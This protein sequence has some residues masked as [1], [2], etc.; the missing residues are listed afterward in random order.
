[1]VR[2][3]SAGLALGLAGFAATA[4]AEPAP[5][6]RPPFPKLAQEE[7]AAPPRPVPA[8]PA[9][10]APAQPVPTP[11]A[12]A[13]PAQ[14][15]AV[16]EPVKLSADPTPTLGPGTFVA[17][18]NA[19]ERYRAIAEAG[20]WA[21]V[22]N[23]ITR[24]KPGDRGPHV[25]ALRARLIASGDLSADL[26][27]GDA[28]DE[29]VQAAIRRFQDRHG[30][31]ALGLVGPRTLVELN[32][33]V[34]VRIR[35]LQASANRLMGSRFPFG[36]RYVAVNIPAATVEAVQGGVVAKRHVAVV[37]KTDRPSPTI[38]ARI[39]NVNFNPTWTVPV[40]LIRKDIIP[41]M[42]KDPGYLAR[43]KIR[44]FDGQGAEIDPATIDWSTDKAATYTLR[45]DPG[46]DNSLGEIRIDMPN[47]LAVY[48]HDTPSKKLF[49][50]NARNLSSGCVRVS[51]IRELAQW[52]LEGQ[53]GP[54][55]PGSSWGQAEIAAAIASGQRIDVKLTR[56][57]PVI[58][59]YLTGYATPD[60]TVHFRE[61]IYGLDREAAPA[62]PEGGE[63]LTIESL[64]TGALGG[65]GG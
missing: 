12:Q 33:P 40:S 54:N 48:M 22:P 26:A 7:P 51:G 28:L 25:A 62:A 53:P 55:G 50:R 37:G 19:V 16:P 60:G 44:I 11:G 38:A 61:D 49:A 21:T 46:V 3:G 8:L 31:P 57:I 63:G 42:R 43:M 52:V 47:K 5:A 10:P 35:Q 15:A 41:H 29:A 36:E 59:T 18:M 14:P 64:V 32:V 1:M 27:G 56:Q 9:V 6:P 34:S 17:T 30:L 65:R 2:S 23:E 4:L 45:Q 24:A 58:W 13:K 39:Q 20:G